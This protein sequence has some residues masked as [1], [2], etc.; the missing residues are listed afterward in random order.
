[1]YKKLVALILL[2]SI[3]LI[4]PACAAADAPYVVD[5]VDALKEEVNAAW[6]GRTASSPVDLLYLGSCNG[7]HIVEFYPSVVQPAVTTKHVAGY[8][9]TRWNTFHLKAYKNGAFIELED[10]Y[11]L[12]L[13]SEEAIAKASGLSAEKKDAT[14]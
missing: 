3:L 11:Q 12:G 10:A 6:K 13:I 5:D 7:Y 14:K 1:M 2:C 9:F 8:E 4:L